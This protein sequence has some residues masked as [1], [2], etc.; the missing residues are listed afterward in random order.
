MAAQPPLAVPHRTRLQLG[1]GSDSEPVAAVGHP[2]TNDADG[3]RRQQRPHDGQCEVG[4]QPERNESGPKDLAFHSFIL[5]RP[6]PRGRRA[7]PRFPR[8]NTSPEQSCP[9]IWSAFRRGPPG[10]SSNIFSTLDQP[11]RDFRPARQGRA[12]NWTPRDGLTL[13]DS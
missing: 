13:V 10:H 5:A 6:T 2:P 3:N 12:R 4:Y 7:G 8:R 1:I 11:R 9:G